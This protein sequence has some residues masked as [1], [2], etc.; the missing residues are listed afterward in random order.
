MFDKVR[1]IAIESSIIN[2]KRISREGSNTMLSNLALVAMT[3][4]K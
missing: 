2:I 4:H 3:F 1:F